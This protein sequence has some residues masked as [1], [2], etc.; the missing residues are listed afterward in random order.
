MFP[1]SCQTAFP[2][3]TCHGKAA[4]RSERVRAVKP[5]LP[6]L[7]CFSVAC[8]HPSDGL[9]QHMRRVGR[10]DT[11][12]PADRQ[13]HRRGNCFGRFIRAADGAARYDIFH[14]AHKFR[15]FRHAAPP[16]VVVSSQR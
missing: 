12:M 4:F 2:E 16:V 14:F 1:E 8:S 5:V 11:E 7:P 6:P 15:I 9:Q 13:H 3:R 10:A